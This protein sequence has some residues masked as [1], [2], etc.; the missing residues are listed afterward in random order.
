M[1][2]HVPDGTTYVFHANYSVANVL[3]NSERKT[4]AYQPKKANQ[5]RHYLT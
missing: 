4:F 5:L 1:E 2:Y 3:V